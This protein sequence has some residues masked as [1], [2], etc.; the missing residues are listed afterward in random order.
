VF[1]KTWILYTGMPTSDET[2][3]SAKNA[4]LWTGK[5]PIDE[6]DELVLVR[7]RGLNSI[8]VLNSTSIKLAA[9]LD[10]PHHEGTGG[11][12]DFVSKGE[13]GKHINKNKRWASKRKKNDKRKL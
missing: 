6:W 5:L 2:L 12:E 4:N 9:S 8:G 11:E 13:Y 7:N 1:A 10:I 3:G